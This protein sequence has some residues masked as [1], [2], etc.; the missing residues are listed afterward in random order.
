MVCKRFRTLKTSPTLSSTSQ[1][2]LPDSSTENATSS[3]QVL[4]ECPTP[5]PR[6]DATSRHGNLRDNR[7]TTDEPDKKGNPIQWRPPPSS[8]WRRKMRRA[9]RPGQGAGPGFIYG[10]AITMISL[11]RSF[12]ETD[13]P[14]AGSRPIWVGTGSWVRGSATR[15]R[16]GQV[17]MVPGAQGRG[18]G[19]CRVCGRHSHA[20]CHLHASADS[21]HFTGAACPHHSAGRRSGAA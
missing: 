21:D 1:R 7:G 11:P 13:H 16:D 12:A 18:R 5:L 2:V 9:G 20:R 14:G 8:T 3:P 17:S 6:A 19:A 15:S 4:N 10:S